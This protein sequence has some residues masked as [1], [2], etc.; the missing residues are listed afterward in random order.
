M[1]AKPTLSSKI[2]TAAKLLTY[3]ENV[4]KKSIE[5]AVLFPQAESTIAEL[6]AALEA[7]RNGLVEAAYRDMRQIVIKNQQA[8]TLKQVLYRYALYVEM[9]AN[10]DP[11]IILAAGYIPSKSSTVSI[12]FSPKPHNLRVEIYQGGNNAVQLRVNSWRPARYCQFEYRKVGSGSEWTKVLSTKSKT[13][14]QDLEHL[15]EYEFRVTYLGA[16]PTPNYSDTVR[17]YIV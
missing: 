6:E 12:G 13:V 1:M 3:A 4:L 10:G 2:G 7:Y 11:N 9:V 8:E 5:N 17:C 14:I 15:Q 16:D